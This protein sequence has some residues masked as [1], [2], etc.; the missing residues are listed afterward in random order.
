[1][2]SASEMFSGSSVLHAL[3]VEQSRIENTVSM[4]AVFVF[5]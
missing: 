4:T 2:I 5:H 1:M 3:L